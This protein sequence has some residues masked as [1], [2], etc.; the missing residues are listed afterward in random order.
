MSDAY[1]NRIASRRMTRR[2]ML[3]ATGAAATAAGAVWL[4]GC[5]GSTKTV[6]T[7]GAADATPDAPSDPSKAAFL[8]EKSPATPGGRLVVG[9]PGAF[10][11]FDPHLTVAVALPFMPRIYNTLVNQS[12]TRPEYTFFDLAQSVENPDDVTWVF[13]I[14]PGVRIGPNDLGVPERDLDGQD[15]VASFERIKSSPS[16]TNGAFAKEFVD[17][18][19]AAG[20]TVTI[21]TTQPY[22]WLISRSGNFANTIAPRELLASDDL[23]KKIRTQSAGGGPFRL[24]SSTEGDGAV[25]DRNPSYYRRDENGGAALPYIEGLD[26]R[27]FTDRTAWRTA[28]QSQQLQFY[29]ADSKEEADS[30]GNDSSVFM[31]KAPNFIFVPLTMNPEKPPFNDPRARRAISRAINRDDIIDV[32]YRGDAKPNGLV[33]WPCGIG[34]Y[35]FSADELK[36][37]QPYDPADA[38]ALISAL[39]GMKLTVTYP[40]GAPIAQ[41][42]RHVPIVLQQLRDAGIDVSEDALPLATWLDHYRSRDYTLTIALTQN[43]ESPELPLKWHTANGPAGDKSYGVGL[44]DPDIEAALEKTNTTLDF[45]A[46][47]QAVRDAQKLIYTKDPTFLPLVCGY[48][49]TAYSS[50]VHNVPDG[51]GTTAQFLNTM[52]LE[53]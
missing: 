22:A 23:L 37:L 39:G 14:R 42:D 8:N 50:R 12:A 51:L 47:V 43:I 24:V 34:T 1:W 48:T 19:T 3:Q 38:K 45:Q 41:H 53:S 10:D 15:V 40:T 29:I 9:V 28:F 4:A 49:Y 46:R 7:P 2:R 6:A 25:M 16:A 36:D 44:G 5:G 30:F 33:H 26:V 17:S 11:S 21:K 32:V 27:I 18:V 35:A 20:D 31:Q 52:W 13:K